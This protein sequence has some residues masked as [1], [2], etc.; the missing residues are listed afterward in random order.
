MHGKQRIEQLIKSFGILCRILN[1]GTIGGDRL[2]MFFVDRFRLRL[3]IAFELCR[4]FVVLF[5]IIAF[6][7]GALCGDALIGFR[8]R[9]GRHTRC[10]FFHI[11]QM[12][13]NI[14]FAFRH[15]LPL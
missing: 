3:I 15:R 12:I 2:R 1:F 8:L 6:R 10:A 7:F 13:D 5:F 11:K 14:D 4:N 9:V